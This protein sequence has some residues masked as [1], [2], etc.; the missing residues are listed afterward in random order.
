MLYHERIVHVVK[1]IGLVFDVVGVKLRQRAHKEPRFE[2]ESGVLRHQKRYALQGASLVKI[3]RANVG[4]SAN[5]AIPVLGA[6]G[7]ITLKD[8]HVAPGHGLGIK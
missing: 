4:L 2:K 5:V 1:I 6:F 3:D 7:L 8:P